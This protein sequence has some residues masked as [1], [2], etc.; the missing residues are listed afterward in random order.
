MNV[1]AIVGDFN[2]ANSSHLAT[3]QCLQDVGLRFEWIAT[4]GLEEAAQSSLAR[5]DGVWIAPASPYRSMRGAL[6]AVQYARER[7]VPLVGT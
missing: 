2:A 4:T 3:N 1:I 7:C 6:N 5:F